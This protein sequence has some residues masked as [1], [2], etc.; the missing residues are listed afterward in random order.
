MAKEKGSVFCNYCDKQ[1]FPRD[2]TAENKDLYCSQ[3]CENSDEL[4]NLD[5]KNGKKEY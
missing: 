2:S 5:L 1:Y 4:E 3:V